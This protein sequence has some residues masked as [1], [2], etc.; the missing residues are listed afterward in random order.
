MKVEGKFALATVTTENYVQWSMVMIHSFLKSNP[1]FRGDIIVFYNDLTDE[2]ISRLNTFK[3]IRLIVPSEILL[4]KLETLK[5]KVHQ[6]KNIISQFYSLETFNLSGYQKVL[7]LDSDVIVVKSLQELFNT[8]TLLAACPESCWY[9]GKGRNTINYEAVAFDE[10]SDDFI[11]TPVNS[12]FLFINEAMI[13][14]TNFN[15]LINLVDPEL[16]R[17]KQTFH[18]DQMVMNLWFRNQFSILDA[19]YNFRPK[20]TTQIAAKEHITINDAFVIHFI[21]QQKPW[22]FK[23]MILASENDMNLVIAY[24]LWY[25]WYFDFLKHHH[26]RHKLSLLKSGLV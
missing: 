7:F 17:N 20:N 13:N 21:R 14:S 11:E 25:Q 16:W 8:E 2:S 26:L 9:S 4:Q 18:A 19:R 23:E 6:F 10:A 1:W 12:G 22:D 24:E 15:G 5:E 3:Q